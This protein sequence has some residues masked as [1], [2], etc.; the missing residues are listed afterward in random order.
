MNTTD[1]TM[2]LRAWA[3]SRR[4][5]LAT[6]HR[7]VRTGRISRRPDGSIDPHVADAEWAGSMP[8]RIDARA[9]IVPRRDEDVKRGGASG[10]LRGHIGDNP[11]RPLNR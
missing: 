11:P 9:V 6:A 7:A 10:T 2:S 4:I 1:G 5:P 3:A 8:L